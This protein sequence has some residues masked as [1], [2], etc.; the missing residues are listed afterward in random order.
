MDAEFSLQAAVQ[1]TNLTGFEDL[2][3]IE[4]VDTVTTTD[5]LVKSKTKLT[6]RPDI[7]VQKSAAFVLANEFE[8]RCYAMKLDT[9]RRN[10]FV[11][12]IPSRTPSMGSPP[13][14]KLIDVHE[15]LRLQS[16]HK[17]AEDEAEHVERRALAKSSRC[18]QQLPGKSPH[19]LHYASDIDAENGSVTK[20]VSV[21]GVTTTTSL[22]TATVTSSELTAHASDY[23]ISDINVNI[24]DFATTTADSQLIV[25]TATLISPTSSSQVANTAGTLSTPDVTQM[26]KSQLVSTQITPQSTPAKSEVPQSVD[27]LAAVFGVTSGLVPF[28][29]ADVDDVIAAVSGLRV[30]TPASKKAGCWSNIDNQN[31]LFG[32]P[33]TTGLSL[34]PDVDYFRTPLKQADVTQ[35]LDTPTVS[36]IGDALV[37]L[38]PRATTPVSLVSAKSTSRRPTKKSLADVTKN[39]TSSFDSNACGD[40]PTIGPTTQPEPADSTHS[41][42]PSI[43]PTQSTVSCQSVSTASQTSLS[44]QSVSVPST[45]RVSA[46][47]RMSATTQQMT[48]VTTQSIT[49]TTTQPVMSVS[50]QPASSVDNNAPVAC[51]SDL[52]KISHSLPFTTT[53]NC[54]R[55][56]SELWPLRKVY[57]HLGWRLLLTVHVWLQSQNANT[58]R[59][60]PEFC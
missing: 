29:A 19:V 21:V 22:T 52:T 44:S 60:V 25:C 46:S 28:N 3:N 38:P 13:Q 26:I 4:P 58:S 43:V 35:S 39:L 40:G 33:A 36:V 51:A 50:A 56:Q 48:T 1:P 27:L 20:N 15:I 42:S 18:K 23:K 9:V 7:V 10:K 8:R 2:A 55:Y 5:K 57:Y 41:S 17:A 37:K 31:P 6:S 14:L 49:S 59:S 24:S 32:T 53:A 54:Q 47:S 30:T 12:S 34:Q 11:S 16:K 45:A